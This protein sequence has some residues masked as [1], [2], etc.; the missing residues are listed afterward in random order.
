MKPYFEDDGKYKFRKAILEHLVV[1]KG[2]KIQVC[3][4]CVQPILVPAAFKGVWTTPEYY[5]GRCKGGR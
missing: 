1:K 2:Y 5:C 3:P 4:G